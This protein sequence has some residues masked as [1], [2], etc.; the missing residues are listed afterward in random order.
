MLDKLEIIKALV[1][2]DP[3]EAIEEI[4]KIDEEDRDYEIISEWGRA[5]NNLGNYERALELFMSIKEEGEKDKKWNYRVG[6]AYSG[7]EKYEEA[8]KFL[9]KALEINSNYP[10]PYFELGW[11]LKKLGREDE[12][13]DYLEKMLKF[14][15]NDVNT[16]LTMGD[17][18]FERSQF[19]K[20]LECY[21]KVEELGEKDFVL[22]LSLIHI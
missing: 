6:Y 16:F 2:T 9:M 3:K 20:S 22:N 12:A 19:D 5:E 4:L 17:I 10:W 13:L 15:P 7:L 18:Y 21:L 14:E 1:D 11:N 8:N